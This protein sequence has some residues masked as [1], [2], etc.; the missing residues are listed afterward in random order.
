ML[1]SLLHTDEDRSLTLLRVMLGIVF[2]PHGAQKVF[3]WFGGA[4]LAGT[5]HTF[6]QGMGIPALF[7]A[8]AIATEFLGALALIAGFFGRLAALAVAVEMVVAVS[9]VHWANGFFMNW[10]GTQAGE[11]FEYH[12]LVLAI[13]IVLIVRGSGAWSLD[14]LL[15]ARSVPD[16]AAPPL[17]GAASR[18]R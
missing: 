12:L 18:P 10:S 14:R 1:R 5:M 15:G 6:T 16:R 2:L 17:T 11:G 3:G 9:F 13:A 8:L 7:A 4:G